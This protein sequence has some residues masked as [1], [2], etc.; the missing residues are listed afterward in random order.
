MQ[1]LTTTISNAYIKDN[2]NNSDRTKHFI[3]LTLK[4][5]LFYESHELEC[6]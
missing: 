4:K 6:R 3:Y 2:K 1:I 5:P